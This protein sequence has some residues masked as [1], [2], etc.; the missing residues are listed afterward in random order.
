MGASRSKP[1]SSASPPSTS[2]SYVDAKTGVTITF[3]PHCAKHME[4][5]RTSRKMA[6]YLADI[7]PDQ[8][9]ISGVQVH[10]VTMF[11]T[12]VGFIYATASLKDAKTGKPVPGVVL[13]TGPSVAVLIIF[14]VEGAKYILLTNQQRGATGARRT[15][16]LAGMA[17][18][19]GNLGGALIKEARE[20]AGIIIPNISQ[21]ENLGRYWASQG[22]TAEYLQLFAYVVPMSR[23]DFTAMVAKKQAK[24]FGTPDEAIRLVFQPM[25]EDIEKY[26]DAKLEVALGR[27]LRHHAKKI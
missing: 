2:S 24:E 7:Q 11:G 22:R 4:A 21:L 8:L 17:D 6:D 9:V 23:A 20:E 3:P 16:L 1:A 19:D 15:E 10:E 27:Y 5:V 13:I 18:E 25:E 12:M 14:E 26:Q